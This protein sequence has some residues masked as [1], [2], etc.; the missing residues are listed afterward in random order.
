VVALSDRAEHCDEGHSG[1]WVNGEEIT[2]AAKILATIKGAIVQSWVGPQAHEK[3][4]LRGPQRAMGFEPLSK[5]DLAIRPP[6]RPK[7]ERYSV[8]RASLIGRSEITRDHEGSDGL[9]VGR[10]AAHEKALL[11]EGHSGRWDSNH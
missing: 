1:R 2:G 3:G 8:N 10:Q 7:R 9:V 5:P 4:P 6:P 11:P